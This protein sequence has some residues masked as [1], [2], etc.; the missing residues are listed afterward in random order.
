M[1]ASRYNLRMDQRTAE[2]KTKRRK[3]LTTLSFTEKI[4]I[5]EKL[6]DRELAIAAAGLRRSRSRSV[7][8]LDRP[9]NGRGK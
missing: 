4:R 6:R 5:L 8:D 9:T 7:E 1:S 2:S 3:E